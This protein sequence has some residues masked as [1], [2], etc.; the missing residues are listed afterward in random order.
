MYFNPMS[1][2]HSILQSTLLSEIMTKSVFS[3]YE[4]DEFHVVHEKMENH[5][6][7]HL[8]VVNEAGVLVGL[9]TQ[10]YLYKIHSPRKL[11]EGDWYYDKASLD[12]FIL[13]NVMIKEPYTLKSQNTLEEAMRA[14]VQFKF[15]AIIIVDDY[16]IPC[17][18]VTRNDILKFLLTK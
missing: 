7:R 12:N 4:N 13:K 5:D 10:R 15:G 9:I 8:P 2:V 3:V 16:R 17:G 14:M 18:I 6:I 11:E 1:V